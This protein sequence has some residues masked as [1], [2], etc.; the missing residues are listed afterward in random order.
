[1]GAGS[2][3]LSKWAENESGRQRGWVE[4]AARSAFAASGPVGV[5][6]NMYGDYAEGATSA[7]VKV[8]RGLKADGIKERLKK[9][10][11]RNPAEIR[12]EADLEALW[13]LDED[14]DG[15]KYSMMKQRIKDKY[16]KN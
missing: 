15:T 12:E 8:H 14:M 16:S 7:Q 11:D 3:L 1:M 4:T 9:T 6:L 5:A 2:G 10:P 13:L